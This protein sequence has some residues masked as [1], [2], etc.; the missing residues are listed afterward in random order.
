V[1]LKTRILQVF[2]VFRKLTIITKLI[3]VLIT[4]NM[5]AKFTLPLQDFI[6]KVTFCLKKI[7]CKKFNKK[8]TFV[9]EKLNKITVA[10][11]N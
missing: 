6:T 8:L 4:S 7:A 9:L 11:V 10:P 2:F 5:G 1:Y 3:L